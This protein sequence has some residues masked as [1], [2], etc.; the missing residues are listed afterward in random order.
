MRNDDVVPPRMLASSANLA[1]KTRAHCVR[2]YTLDCDRCRSYREPIGLESAR[3]RRVRERS[4]RRFWR[5]CAGRDASAGFTAD[6][7]HHRRRR[8]RASQRSAFIQTWMPPRLLNRSS[9][10][11]RASLACAASEAREAFDWA[12]VSVRTLASSAHMLA[13]AIGRR[14]ARRQFE[15]RTNFRRMMI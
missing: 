4:M 6:G 15:C 3:R 1:R 7:R 10:T 12:A 8:S 13:P 9:P 14:V 2:M 11:H 5:A